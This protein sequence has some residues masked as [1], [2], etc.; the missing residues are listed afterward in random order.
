MQQP[1][2]FC[3]DF[4]A[5]VNEAVEWRGDAGPTREMWIKQLTW[6]GLSAPTW[7]AVAAVHNEDIHKWVIVTRDL[8]PR[9]SPI[10]AL[11][12]SLYAFLTNQPNLAEKET[13]LNRTCWECRKPGHL[14]GDCPRAKPKP[15]CPK[16][17]KGSHWVKDY[18]SQ[19][20]DNRAPLNSRQSAPQPCQQE[21]KHPIIRFSGFCQ[22][23]Y[24]RH[25][26]HI[27]GWATHQ[28]TGRHGCGCH[29]THRKRGIPC[30]SLETQTR[31]AE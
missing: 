1:R 14:R 22:F 6:E 9:A 30:P 5:Q 19:S 16:C 12:N 15:R 11:M 29:Y 20:D 27:P 8:D 18:W 13:S 3:M 21:K 23:F 26:N 24:T 4:L 2:E 25:Y 28:R 10:A 31:P 7:N 17:N